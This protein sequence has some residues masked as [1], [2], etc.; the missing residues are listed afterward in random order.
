MVQNKSYIHGPDQ[1]FTNDDV[2]DLTNQD[3]SLKKATNSQRLQKSSR[4][5]LKVQYKSLPKAFIV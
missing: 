2:S 3:I 5:A 4:E 1:N